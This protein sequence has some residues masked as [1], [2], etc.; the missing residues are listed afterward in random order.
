LALNVCGRGVSAVGVSLRLD[1]DMKA[2]RSSQLTT[3]AKC[4][5]WKHSI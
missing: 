1:G 3:L 2:I 5:A 4:V